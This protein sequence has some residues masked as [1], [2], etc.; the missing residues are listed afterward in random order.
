MGSGTYSRPLRRDRSPSNS[1]SP[2]KG[3]VVSSAGACACAIRGPMG[4]PQAPGSG[5]GWS[6]WAAGTR[7]FYDFSAPDHVSRRLLRSGQRSLGLHFPKAAGATWTS[8]F[9]PPPHCFVLVGAAENQHPASWREFCR[10]RPAHRATWT[11]V[12]GNSE[13]GAC[14]ER[15]GVGPRLPASPACVSRNSWGRAGDCVVWIRGVRPPRLGGV[16]L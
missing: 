3:R 16:S 7:R 12:K 15:R 8:A 2:I 5:V 6:L 14:G 11:S 1:P 13:C 10:V 4:T 9:P